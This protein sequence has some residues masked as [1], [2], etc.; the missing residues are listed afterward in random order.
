MSDITVAKG[1]ATGDFT[2]SPKWVVDFE[3]RFKP[4]DAVQLAVG[5]NNL[6]DEYPDRLTPTGN[7]IFLP[8]SGQSPFGFSGRFVY[9]RASIDF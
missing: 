5:A 2:L 9:G 3:L 7:N 4:V 1:D 6:L 8:Y